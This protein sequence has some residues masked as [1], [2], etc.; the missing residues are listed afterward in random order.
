MDIYC[1]LEARQSAR[2]APEEEIKA[3]EL[4]APSEEAVQG[5]SPAGTKPHKAPESLFWKRVTDA[6]GLL[7]LLV[8]TLCHILYR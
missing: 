5:D 6:S 2:L 3:E 8:T 7:L 1:G 4:G